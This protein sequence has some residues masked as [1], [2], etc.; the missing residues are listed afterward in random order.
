[1]AGGGGGVTVGLQV[2]F[3]PPFC[4]NNGQFVA[5]LT[6]VNVLSEELSRMM[7]MR[8]LSLAVTV[9]NV[10]LFDPKVCPVLLWSKKESSQMPTSLLF[11]VTLVNVLP[12]CYEDKTSP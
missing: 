9:V 1:M 7:L 10:F 11:A 3:V 6:P 2:L 8:L 12:G 4:V 5:G